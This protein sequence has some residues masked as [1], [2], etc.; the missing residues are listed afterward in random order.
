MAAGST[1]LGMVLSPKV[2]W[3]P[4]LPDS[5][6]RW[7]CGRCYVLL[8]GAREVEATASSRSCW[9]TLVNKGHSGTNVQYQNPLLQ[10]LSQSFQI[11][12]QT[13]KPSHGLP[14][15]EQKICARD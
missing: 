11:D 5:M 6:E 2:F 12:G 10:A 7:R 9:L 3:K 14:K 1:G 13:S 4:V 8:R 15:C